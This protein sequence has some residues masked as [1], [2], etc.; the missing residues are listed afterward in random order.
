MGFLRNWREFLPPTLA[1]AAG[2]MECSFRQWER[3]SIYEMVIWQRAH[4]YSEHLSVEK[5][6]C[7]TLLLLWGLI[8][9]HASAKLQQ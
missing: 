5:E 3:Q 6:D 8:R 9:V 7:D 2:L 4:L 1:G